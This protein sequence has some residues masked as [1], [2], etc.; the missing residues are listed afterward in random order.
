MK[1]EIL[2]IVVEENKVVAIVEEEDQVFK[3]V[4]EEVERLH[5]YDHLRI[6][7]TQR[8]ALAWFAR[9]GERDILRMRKDTLDFHE[10]LN[11]VADTFLYYGYAL[12]YHPRDG[13]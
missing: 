7:K 4:G 12:T 10:K 11:R 3:E 2:R 9:I 13:F 1:E 8:D 6:Y 5:M